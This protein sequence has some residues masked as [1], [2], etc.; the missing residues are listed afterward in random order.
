MVGSGE[1]DIDDSLNREAPFEQSETEAKAIVKRDRNAICNILV[2]RV[3]AGLD[4][5]KKVYLILEL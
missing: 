3:Y 2:L 1:K 5:S 4:R